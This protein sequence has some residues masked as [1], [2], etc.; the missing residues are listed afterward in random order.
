MKSKYFE[1]QREKKRQIS[2]LFAFV[3]SKFIIFIASHHSTFMEYDIILCMIIDYMI[4][5]D[6]HIPV[7]RVLAMELSFFFNEF[8]NNE[9]I[10][11][12]IFGL[13]QFS[14]F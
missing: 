11:G 4:S 3:F 7:S 10:D 1:I 5:N 6:K 2:I 12:K 9:M 13:V 14:L 8:Q